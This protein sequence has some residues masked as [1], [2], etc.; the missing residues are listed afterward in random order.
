MEILKKA[1]YIQLVLAIMAI[2]AEQVSAQ[3]IQF[4][5]FYSCPLFL[6][7]SYAG[8]I[9]NSRLVVNYRNQWPEIG[10]FNTYA[11]SYDQ[12]FYKINSGAGIMIMRDVAGDGSLGL[13]DVD[14]SYSWYTKITRDWTFR[15]GLKVKYLQR[16]VNF[17]KL[18]FG[19]MFDE[20]G[21]PS[22]PTGENIPLPKKSY[23]DMQ[24]SSLFYSDK[25]WGGFSV[26]HLLQ[27][28]A[29]LYDDDDY[30]E[31]VKVTVFG[32][33][34]L[35]IGAVPTSRGRRNKDDLQSV[36]FTLLYERMKVAD[37]LNIGAYW[38]KNPFTLGAWIRGIPVAVREDTYGNLDALILMLGYKI[39]DLHIGYSY[40][41]SIGELLS[42]S[43][44]AHEISVM[45]EFMPKAKAKRR[46]TVISCPKL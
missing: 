28:K 36:S 3:I 15:P 45:Y 24:V 19:D 1:V 34:K 20:Y 32:G 14:F 25:Y 12:H 35:Y 8:A 42:V 31:D 22:K 4:S 41:F 6:A 9:D 17:E 46:H 11:C 26:D 44:G 21:V 38:N 29:S 2:S 16:S 10:T 18:L 43:G 5:Q 33:A 7:P 40:D 13:T 37:Q 30:R 39:F 27:P 23:L